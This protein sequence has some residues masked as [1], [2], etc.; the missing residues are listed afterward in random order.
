M[1]QYLESI[2]CRDGAFALAHYHQQ[3]IERTFSEAFHA[4]PGFQL[5]A[6]LKELR[7]P[8][9]GLYKFRMIYG[10]EGIISYGFTPYILPI[11]KSLKLVRK[12]ELAYRHKKADRSILNKAFEERSGCDDI[13]IVQNDKPTDSWFCNLVFKMGDRLHTPLNPL[14]KGIRRAYYLDEEQIIEKDISINQISEYEGVY[15]IN[16]L[17]PLSTAPFIAIDNIKGL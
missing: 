12:D 17:L 4:R 10:K 15:L 11:I 14:L 6:V 13:I 5:K 2:A 8:Q 1:C 7:P 3:R 9:K 16:A